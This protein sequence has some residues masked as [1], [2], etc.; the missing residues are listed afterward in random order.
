MIW[1]TLSRFSR[2]AR[3]SDIIRTTFVNYVGL[4]VTAGTSILVAR[5]L[6]PAG[7]G[8]FAAIM[9]WFALALVLGELGQSGAITYWVAR[10]K[11]RAPS[12]VASGRHLTLV[13]ATV[14]AAGMIALSPTLA[15]GDA[16]LA[17]AYV[18][19]FSACL[20]N[21]VWGPSVYALQAVSIAAWNAVRL[22]Q[23]ILYAVGVVV[24]LVAQLASVLSLAVVLALSMTCQLSI[25]AIIGSRLGLG[26][27]RASRRELVKL[28]RYGVAYAGSQIPATGAAQYDKAF[29][30][31]T[32]S[33]SA[34]GQ[35]AVAT[36]VASLSGP[37]ATA[38]ASVVF[39]RLSR[40]IHDET[41]RR[42]AENRAIL[43]TVGMS[44]L[45][46]AMIAAIAAPVVPALFGREYL[47]AILLVWMLLPS[48]YFRAI[49][50]LNSVFTRS[51][52][53][54][55]LVT[56]SRVSGLVVGV[57][58]IVPLVAMAGP[59][60]AAISVFA[61]EGTT[62]LVSSLILWKLRRSERQG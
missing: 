8:E 45:V 35:Y 38:I 51:R 6:G 62:L 42:K 4:A 41:S 33:T 37:L 56:W 52:G 15:R 34:L 7:R 18:I 55:G 31:Q 25:A 17:I 5:A 29:L 27:G 54:P 11:D 59:G 28:G 20:V 48:M 61:L 19:A 43:I 44:G 1:S 26:G 60:G 23:S 2:R 47:D 57:C 50:E 21:G 12:T 24:V 40:T 46:I 58:L 3:T 14:T 10:L 49:S 30:S 36:T 53:R 22:S 32:V 16:E 13:G 9:T 39:P